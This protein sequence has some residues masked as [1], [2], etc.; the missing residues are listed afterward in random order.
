LI[1]VRKVVNESELQDA[2]AIR[3]EVFVKEQGVAPEDEYDQYDKT[4]I[5][6]IAYDGQDK[7]CGTAR[8]RQTHSGIKLERFAVLKPYRGRGVGAL[9]LKNILHDIEEDP[10][11]SAQKLYLHAQTTAIGFYK[12][13]G[14]EPVGE[15]FL[16][17][18]IRH[19]EMMR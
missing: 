9:L 2:L 5:H 14:F 11:V 8:W 1:K 7:P 12:K 6:F 3:K 10:N 19:Y 15:E 4:S 13:F 17:C 18:G 16:E